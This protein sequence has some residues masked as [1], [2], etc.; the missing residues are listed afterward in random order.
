MFKKF[1]RPPTNLLRSIQLSDLTFVCQDG[2]AHAHQFV[3][4]KHSPFLKKLF[5]NQSTLVGVALNLP[6][7]RG[8]PITL[9]ERREP[10]PMVQ[11]NL[12]DYTVLT[13]NL[14]LDLLYTG[15]T[16][17]CGEIDHNKGQLSIRLLYADL[18]LDPECGGLPDITELDTIEI[19]RTRK[20]GVV[21][22]IEVVTSTTM[23]LDLGVNDIED[24]VKVIVNTS[25]IDG[26][27][28]VPVNHPIEKDGEINELG[29]KEKEN[30][31]DDSELLG[32]DVD[33]LLSED[34]VELDFVPHL[35][36]YGDGP[37][38]MDIS[39]SPIVK[40]AQK[41]KRRKTEEGVS[42]KSGAKFPK[43]LRRSNRVSSKPEDRQKL[44]SHTCGYLPNRRTKLAVEFYDSDD[45]EIYEA[46]KKKKSN[47]SKCIKDPNERVL[48]PEDIT[49]TML[50]KVCDR[51][52]EKVYNQTIGTS[53]HQCRQKTTDMKTI[54][55]SGECVG[56]RGQF[57]GRCLTLR[58]GEDAREALMNPTWACPP[59]RNFCNCSIC[60]NRKGKGATGV[61]IQLAKSKGYSN[62]ADYLKA[63]MTRKA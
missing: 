15:K 4:E 61:L 52:G 48:M 45:Y 47:F 57:C 43:E 17:Q 12:P 39:P 3:L 29:L 32:I 34:E 31:D 21:P 25:I 58:Y 62:A 14:F 23:D 56:V 46:A 24:E 55:R 28:E 37:S 26:V 60:R 10:S 42:F 2:V 7:V 38:L 33:Y 5:S 49:E 53:C 19:K 44:G 27:N 63:L 35:P 51:F 8:L 41:R 59:C 1:C 36:P 54:C 30:S 16:D 20:V 18:G 50:N 13:V 6:T 9:K 11:L 40:P 22:F